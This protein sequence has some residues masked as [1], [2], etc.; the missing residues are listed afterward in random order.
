MASFA[1]IGLGTNVL[2]K[3]AVV[4]DQWEKVRRKTGEAR[5]PPNTQ[6]FKQSAISPAA[7]AF[8]CVLYSFGEK[9]ETQ[10]KAVE[11]ASKIEAIKAAIE[12][13]PE[14]DALL[15]YI[16]T[17]Q[18]VSEQVVQIFVERGSRLP[19]LHKAMIVT[20]TSDV[21]D[22]VIG[23]QV[24]QNAVN[25]IH[26]F[27]VVGR[28]PRHSRS[29]VFIGSCLSPFRVLAL[30]SQHNERFALGVWRMAFRVFGGYGD[31]A[32]TVSRLGFGRLGGD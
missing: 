17:D 2:K 8:G 22:F 27:S 10:D 30:S 3:N 16:H 20:A 19:L 14:V 29:S 12:A 15:V 26:C 4:N 18:I 6:P 32:P 7:G 23:L 21:K 24:I 25:A 1:K 28:I 5:G 9:C 13:L 31:T 11:M